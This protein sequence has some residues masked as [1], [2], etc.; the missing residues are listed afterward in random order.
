M[1]T[2]IAVKSFRIMLF[3]NGGKTSFDVECFFPACKASKL[4]Y[5]ALALYGLLLITICI[6][7]AGNF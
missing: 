7:L 4:C 2:Y 5:V 3:A 6:F 1:H